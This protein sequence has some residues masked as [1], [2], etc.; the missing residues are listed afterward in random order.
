[1]LRQWQAITQPASG[2]DGKP[3]TIILMWLLTLDSANSLECIGLIRAPVG[4]PPEE[5]Q[6]TDVVLREVA[7]ILESVQIR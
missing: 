2:P 4:T 3:A 7:S 6:D 1:M 5:Q